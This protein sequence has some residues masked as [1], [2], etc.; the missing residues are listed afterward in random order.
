M[1]F[2]QYHATIYAT[3]NL[4]T[5]DYYG[6]DDDDDDGDDDDKVPANSICKRT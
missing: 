2:L 3:P 5:N 4:Q 1:W 6:D